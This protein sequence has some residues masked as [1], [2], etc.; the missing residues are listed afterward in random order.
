MCCRRRIRFR[1]ASLFDARPLV[2]FHQIPPCDEGPLYT[3]DKF[4]LVAI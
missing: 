1:Y 4:L 2:I 3:M